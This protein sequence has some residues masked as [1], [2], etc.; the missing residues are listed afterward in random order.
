M[1]TMLNS[2]AQN[3]NVEAEVNDGFISFACPRCQKKRKIDV[4]KFNQHMN[5]F[6]IYCYCQSIVS[7]KL[8]FPDPTTQSFQPNGVFTNFSRG[9]LHSKFVIQQETASQIDIRILGNHLAREG[10][11]VKIQ[12]WNTITRKDIIQTAVILQIKGKMLLCEPTQTSAA[13]HQL[14]QEY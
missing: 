7:V 11:R 12:Y 2:H 8:Q 10:D 14:F 4:R 5:Y 3:Y 9:S 6:R 13:G 1:K